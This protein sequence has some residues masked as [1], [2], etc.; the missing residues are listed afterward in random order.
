MQSF[1]IPAAFN[2]TAGKKKSNEISKLYITKSNSQKSTEINAWPKKD[3]TRT[4]S[5]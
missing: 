1:R 4:C 2:V 3:V 5:V